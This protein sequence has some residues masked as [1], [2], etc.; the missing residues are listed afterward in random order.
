MWALQKMTFWKMLMSVVS[1]L[2]AGYCAFALSGV[3]A[4]V[5]DK[6]SLKRMWKGI[7]LYPFFMAS[8]TVLN[9]VCL[10]KKDV[11]WEKIEHVKNVSIEEMP[12]HNSNARRRVK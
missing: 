3:L 8:W 10:F 11:E 4:L 12:K 1:M 6:R 5:M 2:V 9:V 7:L